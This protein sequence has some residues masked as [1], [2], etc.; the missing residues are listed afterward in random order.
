MGSA[1]ERA[2]PALLGFPPSVNEVV[3]GL[4]L[5]GGPDLLMVASAALMG[6]DNLEYLLGR[7]GAWGRRILRWDTVT[8]TRYTIGLWVLTISF[9][10]PVVITLFFD[11]IVVNADRSTGWGY[12]LIIGC[13]VVFVTAFL[14][15]GAPLWRRMEAIFDWNAEIVLSTDEPRDAAEPSAAPS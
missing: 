7:V 8:Q 10:V 11:G 13:S 9:L 3:M 12:Y 1:S 5:A 15:M 14:S 4:S 2:E 6:K